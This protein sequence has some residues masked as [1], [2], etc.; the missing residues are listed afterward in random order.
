MSTFGLWT[1]CL[2]LLTGALAIPTNQGSS[3][4]ERCQASLAASGASDKF[5]ANAAH[6]THSITLQELRR[7]DPSAKA[8]NGIA[9]I[10]TNLS[11]HPLIRRHA[12]DV[13][14]ESDFATEAMRA[15]DAVM[16]HREEADWGQRE[17]TTAGRIIHAL[18]MLEMW[19]ELRVIYPQV[20][21]QPPSSEACVCAR[22][23]ENNGILQG[24]RK[25]AMVFTI[26]QLI[27]MDG[28][29]E[30]VDSMMSPHHQ[31]A[32]YDA[33]ESVLKL[34]EDKRARA[35]TEAE[36]AVSARLLQETAKMTV[37]DAAIYIW[38]SLNTPQGASAL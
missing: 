25:A 29:T 18:H 24:M 2:L 6:L 19:Q 15:V 35:Q 3:T 12:P 27:Y 33:S 30:D 38:C 23:V 8:E 22:D 5:A 10:A 31:S 21:R 36:W 16:R 7:L 32:I 20:A 17:V 26:P 13:P 1:L 37:K 4:S 34:S 9:T 14:E 28:F 11:A